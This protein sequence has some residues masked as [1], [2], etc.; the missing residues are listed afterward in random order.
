MDWSKL[1]DVLAVGLLAW[2]F[3]SVARRSYAPVSAHWMTGWVLIVIHFTFLIFVNGPGKLG[4]WADTAEVLALVLAGLL[5]TRASVPYKGEHSSRLMLWVLLAGYTV[6]VAALMLE[7][8]GWVLNA[9]AALLGIGP[10]AVAFA[11]VRRFNH[12]L[13][14][15]TAILTA[16]LGVVLLVVQNRPDGAGVALNATL[17]TVYLSC[18]VHFA[19]MYR[20]ATAGALISIIGFFLWASVFVVGPLMMAFFPGVHLES[21]VWNLPKYVVAVGMILLLLEDQIAH[22]KHLALHDDL[23]GLPNRRL[24]Q[25]RLASAVER[26]RRT[27]AQTAL[28]MMDLDH[29]KQVNDTLGHHAGDLLLQ[30]VAR[31]FSGRVRRSDTVART[32]GDE[33]A[34]ILESPISRDEAMHVGEDLLKL[35]NEP[36]V[37]KNRTIRVGGSLGIALFP[38]DAGDVESLSITADMRMYENKRS[39]ARE[40]DE[41]F[42]CDEVLAVEPRSGLRMVQ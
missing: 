28:L 33:F 18:A 13:R 23:T 11:Y 38:E 37:L 39:N 16:A 12:L 40:G 15:F 14:W 5:F 6:Y 9:A 34:V 7:A 20:R 4:E 42:R 22:T 3:A 2:G 41:A 27:R 21:E 1:P 26:A 35:L 10:L 29:F 17:F 36:M 30:N 25:D 24:F 8:P 31:M 32:G 19:Y